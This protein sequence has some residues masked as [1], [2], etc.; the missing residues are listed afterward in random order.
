MTQVLGSM[1]KLDATRGIVRVE[2]VYD[3]DIEDLWSALTEPDRLSR[4]IATVKGDLRLG[5]D[6]MLHFTSTWEGPARVSVCDRPHRLLLTVEPDTA[7]EAEMEAVLT[8]EGART[9]LVVEDRGLPLDTLHNYGA[10]WQAHLDDLRRYLGGGESAW[11]ERWEELTPIY[12]ELGL[13]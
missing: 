3:T 10:G 4:W 8:A 7:D 2:D 1:R 6:I 11:R 13:N 9:R 12:K 5:G